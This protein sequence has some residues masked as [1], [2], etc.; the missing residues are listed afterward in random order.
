MTS[1]GLVLDSRYRL[2]ERLATGGMGEVWR[3]DD[4]LLSRPV[5]VKLLR[6]EH[7]SDEQ[8]RARFR[9]EARYAAALQHAGIAQVYDY[10]E[11]DERAYLVMELV[12]G[13]PLSRILAQRGPL[14]PQTTLDVV[15]Q[16]ARALQVAHSAGIVHRD[17]KPGNLMVSADGTVKITDFGIAR[18][19][20]V[21]TLTQTGMVMGTAH[22]VSPEQA[23]GQKVTFASDL[24]SLGVV[25]YECL[26]GRPPFDAEQ[27]VAIALKHVREAPPELP[28]EVPEPV[29]G[30]V[31]AMLAKDPADRPA[32]AQEVADEA[33][34]IHDA[35]VAG[36]PLE[37]LYGA[38]FPVDPGDRATAAVPGPDDPDARSAGIPTAWSD[39]DG[40]DTPDTLA[41]VKSPDS[42]GNARFATVGAPARGPMQR[43]IMLVAAS[44]AAGV[45]LLGFIVAGTLG[46][47]PASADLQETTDRAPSTAPG[48]TRTVPSE[49]PSSAGPSGLPAPVDRPSYGNNSTASTT[50]TPSASSTGRPTTPPP[51]PT[52]SERPP[53]TSPPPKTPD[54]GSTE[55]EPENP[56]GEGLPSQ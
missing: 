44:A 55:P 40:G 12:S 32:S 50:P 11:H 21:S 20:S 6:Q 46:R 1:A 43:R 29:R 52:T 35:L 48:S 10:G 27:P 49:V 3:G 19:L 24:Y 8:A 18:G 56:G 38:G 15:A 9:A 26:T 4:E 31:R 51:S 34:L 28:E 42:D 7:V 22:Y 53:T 25:A 14:S 39:L 16:A 45:L 30:L 41:G 5:A 33:Y 23:S 54:P 47:G 36:E 37:G 2:L 17:V 13:E